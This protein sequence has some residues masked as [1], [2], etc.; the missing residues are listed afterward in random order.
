[1][2]ENI[3]NNLV[4]PEVVM[5]Y[6]KY[7]GS[8]QAFWSYDK[9]V[10]YGINSNNPSNILEQEIV[11]KDIDGKLYQQDITLCIVPNK[12]RRE[13]N[14]VIEGVDYGDGEPEVICFDAWNEE[15]NDEIYVQRSKENF[16]NA[17]SFQNPDWDKIGVY[18]VH[19]KVNDDNKTLSIRNDLLFEVD[20]KENKETKH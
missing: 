18:R 2:F 5:V 3:N 4:S 16:K 1:M 13:T 20:M 9:A 15:Y 10:E 19:V 6:Y 17:K 12:K 8:D 7:S 14:Y 11:F